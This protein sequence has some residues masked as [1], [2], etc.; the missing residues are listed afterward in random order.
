MIDI[1]T[2]VE[3]AEY[4]DARTLANHALSIARREGKPTTDLHASIFIDR[5]RLQ[6]TSLLITAARIC[7]ANGTAP[8]DRLLDLADRLW[9]LHPDDHEARW[10]LL[11]DVQELIEREMLDAAERADGGNH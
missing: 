9:R 3:T 6:G 10:M 5:A 11:R 4:L 1:A 2:E 8:E 7:M